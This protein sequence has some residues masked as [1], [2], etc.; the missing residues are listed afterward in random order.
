[1]ARVR[2]DTGRGFAKVILVSLATLYQS[3]REM[4]TSLYEMVTPSPKRDS[5]TLTPT[6]SA[7]NCAT[8]EVASASRAIAVDA[9]M[10]ERSGLNYVYMLT[11][12]ALLKPSRF[13]GYGTPAVLARLAMLGSMVSAVLERYLEDRC[14][15]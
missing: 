7:G 9:I 6:G 1:M 13:R 12:F 8:A 2:P 4:P 15:R 3:A 11:G 14:G 5:N 10:M